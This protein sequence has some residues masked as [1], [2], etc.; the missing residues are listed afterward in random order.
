MT[1][2]KAGVFTPRLLFYT[3]SFLRNSKVVWVITIHT[4]PLYV[5]PCF[6]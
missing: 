6:R 4:I 5:A 3:L 2:K 1:I